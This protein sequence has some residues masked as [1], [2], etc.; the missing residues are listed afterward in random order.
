MDTATTAT[1]LH[2]CESDDPNVPKEEAFTLPP[3]YDP[4]AVGPAPQESRPAATNGHDETQPQMSDVVKRLLKTRFCRYGL[5]CKY[6][7]KCFYAHS[8]E[9]L[10]QRP[11]PPPG[12]RKAFPP[13]HAAPFPPEHMAAMMAQQDPT[14]SYPPPLAFLPEAMAQLM[15]PMG[16]LRVNMMPHGIP[17]PPT[18]N[19]HSGSAAPAPAVPPPGIYGS[20][21]TKAPIIANM[22]EYMAVRPSHSGLTAAQIA[23]LL[24][25]AAST[26][27]A[28]KEKLEGK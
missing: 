6:G 4:E 11:P 13:A 9:E 22:P 17:E 28:R 1:P 20:A 14:M 19:A 23:N 5:H 18:D 27:K 2:M 8:P 3:A 24:E 25:V 7:A 16:D 15:P 21:P 26:A 12:Y 10:R